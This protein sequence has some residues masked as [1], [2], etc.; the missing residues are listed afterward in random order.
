MCASESDVDVRRLSGEEQKRYY[1][2]LLF[3]GIF[4]DGA[5]AHRMQ[6]GLAGKTVA[7]IGM[8]GIGSAAAYLL[9]AAGVGCLRGAD[10]DTIELGNLTRQVLYRTADVGRLKVEAAAER[11]AEFN[12]GVRFEARPEAMT[13]PD[14][15]LSVIEGC[16]FAILSA[17]TPS[18]LSSWMNEACVKA[19][20]PFTSSGYSGH[21]VVCGPLVV[22]GR[23]AC[24]A[25]AGEHAGCAAAD[26]AVA[27]INARHAVPSFGPINHLSASLACAE[28]LKYLTG[29][30]VPETLGTRFL[31]DPMRFE[32]RR[33]SVARR[34]DCPA[35]SHA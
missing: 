2:H 7:L 23:T 25:C 31:F 22:P 13:S 34:A 16:D 12:P 11:L 26:E 6:A 30:S 20:V 14:D 24:L 18:R 17:D 28:A 21:L 10:P 3:Y 19:G 4:H 32:S 9:A 35:C 33:V 27:A 15:I 5:E 1:K 8:G 29:C